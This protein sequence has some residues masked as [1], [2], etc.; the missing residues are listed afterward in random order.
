MGNVKTFKF[1][2]EQVNVL[3]EY[4]M[5]EMCTNQEISK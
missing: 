5:M 3:L 4:F 1:N 2:I